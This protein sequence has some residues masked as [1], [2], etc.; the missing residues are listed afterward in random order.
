MALPFTEQLNL[1]SR[2][3][4]LYFEGQQHITVCIGSG[5]SSGKMPRLE[6]LISRALFNLPVDQK[7]RAFFLEYSKAEFFAENLARRG[8][9]SS[10]PT[11]LDEFRAL[12][13]QDRDTLCEPIRSMY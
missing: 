2:A 4:G 7:T 11:T 1:V 13:P 9:T 8:G 3:L 6:Q 5:A 12:Q 10:N